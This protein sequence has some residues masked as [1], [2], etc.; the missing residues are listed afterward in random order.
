MRKGWDRSAWRSLRE[1]LTSTYR[2]LKDRSQKDEARLFSV[3]STDRTLKHWTT[4]SSIWK[5]ERIYLRVRKHWSK[6]S[7]EFVESPPL[8]TSCATDCRKPTLSDLQWS[9]PSLMIL[10]FYLPSVSDQGQENLHAS[11]CSIGKLTPNTYY[12]SIA[13][14]GLMLF[15]SFMRD[16][17]AFTHTQSRNA[18]LVLQKMQVKGKM[19]LKNLFPLVGVNSTLQ[20]LNVRT[21]LLKLHKKI[22]PQTGFRYLVQTVNN[23]HACL[24]DRLEHCIHLA[25]DAQW[26]ANSCIIMCYSSWFMLQKLQGASL[27]VLSDCCT[28]SFHA[29]SF[30]FW[31][32][33]QW[34]LKSKSALKNH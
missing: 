3:V 21:N 31:M 15:I 18:P 30:W 4:G 33:H 29:R 14:S 5:W 26:C 17:E 16:C 11:K 23:F 1:D 8:D 7:W 2:Y 28:S 32:P 25:G 12:A 20:A 34:L 9:L 13:V 22:M 27:L 24:T 10:W 19:L 6:L